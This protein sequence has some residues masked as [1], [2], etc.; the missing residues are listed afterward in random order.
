MCNQALSNWR[1][2]ARQKYEE[3][4]M[5]AF[6]IGFGETL[7]VALAIAAVMAVIRR[8]NRGEL[9]EAVWYGAGAGALVSFSIGTGLA[10]QR[11]SAGV[12]YGSLQLVMA[13]LT[14]L[15]FGGLL[16]ALRRPVGDAAAGWAAILTALLAVLPHGVAIMGRL[17]GVNSSLPVT[18]GSGALG[19]VAAIL[20]GV[21]LFAGLMRLSLPQLKTPEPRRLATVKQE[22]EKR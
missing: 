3:S 21:L 20:L 18:L 11:S 1:T 8:L 13:V 14:V 12:S 4:I 15:A 17:A 9:A 6:L 5:A 19:M 16:L 22:I 10:M 7:A 2:T